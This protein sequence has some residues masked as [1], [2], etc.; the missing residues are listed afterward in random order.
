MVVVRT[1]VLQTVA[2]RMH[3]NHRNGQ[4]ESDV[5]DTSQLGTPPR[6]NRGRNCVLVSLG[7]RRYR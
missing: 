1:T 3:S 4:E 5:F 6:K 2:G 7:K